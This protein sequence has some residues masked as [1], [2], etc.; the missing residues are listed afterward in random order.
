MFVDVDSNNKTGLAGVDYMT[1]ITWNGSSWIRTLAELSID[2]GVKVLE[3]NNN[4]TGFFEKQGSNYVNL[5]FNLNKVGH[6]DQYLVAFFIEDRLFSNLGQGIFDFTNWV[7]IPPPQYVISAFPNSIVLRPGEEKKVELEVKSIALP[8][9]TE[10]KLYLHVGSQPPDMN[11][12]LTPD[13]T[14]IPFNGIAHSLLQVRISNN[15]TEHPSFTL[16]LVAEI[17]IP[18]S[19]LGNS[20]STLPVSPSFLTI[21]VLPPFSLEERFNNFYTTWFSP[22]SAIWTFFAGVAATL[23]PIIIHRKRSKGGGKPS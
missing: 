6:P 4:F 20:N 3:Q 15:A 8:T 18:S 17:S 7:R 1:T 19:Y 5:F 21:T 2:G 23:G 16:P 12:T 11:M 13:K 14:T 9:R 22:V 10:P